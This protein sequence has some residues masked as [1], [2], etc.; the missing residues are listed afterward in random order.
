MSLL[1][2]IDGTAAAVLL[3]AVARVARGLGGVV[4]DHAG[5]AAMA[6]AAASNDVDARGRLCGGDRVLVTC[7]SRRGDAAAGV[8]D[9]RGA[10]AVRCGSPCHRSRRA[11]F[12]AVL[13]WAIVL[14]VAVVP[15]RTGAEVATPGASLN[16]VS[17]GSDV[18]DNV[19]VQEAR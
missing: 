14:E 15:R 10:A 19:T 17:L 3:A 9:D 7:S 6:V 4:V 11:V 13:W 18:T 2:G 12:C 16:N 1:H 5:L 8:N